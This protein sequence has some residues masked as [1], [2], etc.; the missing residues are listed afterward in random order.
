MSAAVAQPISS[1]SRPA[2]PTIFSPTSQTH[3]KNKGPGSPASSLGSTM[4]RPMQGSCSS[5]G[6]SLR[7]RL[8]NTVLQGTDALNVAQRSRP[9]GSEAKPSALPA[10]SGPPALLGTKSSFGVTC[11]FLFSYSTSFH[12]LNLIN[13]CRFCLHLGRYSQRQRREITGLSAQVHVPYRL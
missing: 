11:G 9:Q 7:T 8:I 4:P 5:L 3:L 1:R 13:Q 2:L 10:W 12:D 6:C